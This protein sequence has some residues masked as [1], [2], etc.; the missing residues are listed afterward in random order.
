M[1][2]M[3][4]PALQLSNIPLLNDSH[5]EVKLSLTYSNTSGSQSVVPSATVASS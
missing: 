3:N 5:Q 1:T 2:K 4:I